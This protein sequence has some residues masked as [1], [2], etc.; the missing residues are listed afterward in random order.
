MKPPSTR[1]LSAFS[2]AVL[3]SF[4]VS[5]QGSF[6]NFS[7]LAPAAQSQ[8][9]VLPATHTFQRLIRS[10]DALTLGGNLGNN[11]DFSGY[12]PISSSSRNGYLSISNETSPAGVAILGISYNYV[13][14]T[15]TV[16]NS[17]NVPFPSAQIGVVARFCSGTVTPA[18]T[19]IVSEEDVT[20]GDV[21]SDG[22][23]DRGWL[24][25][26]DPATRTVINQDG[27]G[28]VDKLW[29]IGRTNRENAAITSDGAVLYTGADD[30]SMG[31]LYKFIPTVANNYSSGT[32]YVLET[33]AALGNGTWRP[34]ANT[35]QAQRNNIRAASS[36]AG[37][38]NFNGIEDVEI[39]PNGMIYF[40][41]KGEGKVYR[42]TDN[43]TFGNSNDIS[44]LNVFAGNDAYPTIKTYDVDGPGGAAAEPWGRGNDNLAFDGDGNL[45]VC[46][47]AIVAS[48]RNY[49]WV[50]APGHTQASPQV[51]IFAR[52]PTRSEPTGITFTPDYKFMFVSFMSPTGT[53]S[54]PQT[55]AAGTSVIF[56]THTTVV[57]AR[58]ENLGAFSTL[59]VTFTG[60][61]VKP[62]GSGAMI[63]WT[64]TDINNHDY[65]AVERSLNGTD[66][67]EIHRNNE[68]M[69]GVSQR[70]FNV[71]DP[72][73][74]ETGIVYY[75]VKQCDVNGS[76]RYT[77]VKSIQRDNRDQITQIFPQPASDMITIRYF[78]ISAGS[79]TVTVTDIHGKIVTVRTRNL[80][81]GEQSI[82]LDISKLSNGVYLV[83]ITDRNNNK[84]SERFVRQ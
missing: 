25:E 10:G 35:T 18:G 68:D 74:P 73:F 33:T 37:A 7:S 27:V 9:L 55:D 47:D 32:L 78:A 44:G 63:S 31:Y 57:I 19:I 52:T 60:F 80:S 70:S 64:A 69:N 43:G 51:K 16:N 49:I 4:S 42:F 53:N 62:T 12:V 34:V 5:A 81:K 79:A 66:F 6:G 77:D 41:A 20:T 8:N 82:P 67:Q 59:P 29:A 36:T 28:G 17:G 14:H 50:V 38:Y 61:D 26:I 21:N 58:M 23:T 13:S 76:C 30:A 54:T 56:N 15:W 83:T 1:E 39:G 71:E 2:V 46:Q 72:T 48:D 40:S 24:I 11:L 84:V 65:F 75:R 22:Y 45:Y 3:F